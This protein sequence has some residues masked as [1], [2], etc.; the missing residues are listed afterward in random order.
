MSHKY[1]ELNDNLT[2]RMVISSRKSIISKSCISTK[3]HFQLIRKT[4]YNRAVMFIE[5]L[6]LRLQNSKHIDE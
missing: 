1:K 5:V 6:G 4:K 3:R 2:I